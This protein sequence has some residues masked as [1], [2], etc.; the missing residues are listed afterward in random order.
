MDS[1]IDD[2]NEGTLKKKVYSK[3]NEEKHWLLQQQPQMAPT[4][5]SRYGFWWWNGW[6]EAPVED[7]PAL[8]T[9]H[10]MELKLMKM[11]TQKILNN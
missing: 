8:V 5:P 2:L 7:K 1:I 3:V 6:V 9:N 4:A 10:L 11:L